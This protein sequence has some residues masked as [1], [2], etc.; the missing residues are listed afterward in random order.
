MEEANNLGFKNLRDYIDHLIKKAK[1]GSTDK[2]RILSINKLGQIGDSIAV[3]HLVD[4]MKEGT[5][6]LKVSAIDALSQIGNEEAITPLI[7]ELNNSHRIE[8]Q[9]PIVEA[10]GAIGNTVVVDNLILKLEDSYF[11]A[12]YNS[13]LDNELYR[14]SLADA[15]SK[16]GETQWLLV[17]DEEYIDPNKF[18]SIS[19]QRVSDL[20]IEILWRH[21]GNSKHCIAFESNPDRRLLKLLI[22]YASEEARDDMGKS[23]I[24]R[25]K[26]ALIK[27]GE[28]KWIKIIEIFAKHI[29]PEYEVSD[30]SPIRRF[31]DILLAEY[32]KLV[33]KSDLKLSE[34][35]NQKIIDILHSTLN[36]KDIFFKFYSSIVL[37][38]LGDNKA[39]DQLIDNLSDHHHRVRESAAIALGL[40]GDGIAVSPL[41]DLLTKERESFIAGSYEI[42]EKVIQLNAL[43]SYIES[44]NKMNRKV[45]ESDGTEFI[46]YSCEEIIDN[47]SYD[48]ADALYT[49]VFKYFYFKDSPSHNIC[50]AALGAL[51]KVESNQ[52][53]EDFNTAFASDISNLKDFCL[54]KLGKSN[55]CNFLSDELS[56]LSAKLPLD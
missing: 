5:E 47:G 39:V 15:L 44:K 37:G 1:D 4:I 45:A 50:R 55:R 10:L 8:I 54:D 9:I 52:I 16:L 28:G 49:E 7:E 30:E 24:Q 40:I 31:I 43:E 38:V 36:S 19:D 25:S 27:L 20:F 2:I 29:I 51:K 6:E 35:E 32:E 41:T 14:R 21:Y 13:S 34:L 56:S 48:K 26:N 53:V 17:C 18:V 42:I 11:E 46:P 3:K 23:N 12:N 22:Y 33:Q